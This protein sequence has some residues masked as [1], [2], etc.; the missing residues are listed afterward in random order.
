MTVV[1]ANMSEDMRR[2]DATSAMVSTQSTSPLAAIVD[3]MRIAIARYRYRR[4]IES[5]SRFRPHAAGLY[6]VTPIAFDTAFVTRGLEG[7]LRVW[8]LREEGQIALAAI[9]PMRC[10]RGLSAVIA[11]ERAPVV[12]CATSEG[13]ARWDLREPK[14]AHTD[15]FQGRLLHVSPDGEWLAAA[16]LRKVLL[17]HAP[18][19]RRTATPPMRQRKSRPYG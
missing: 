19:G 11:A 12:A 4:T 10:L 13:L 16:R 7:E 15:G 14:R 8:R 1:T 18:S 9:S 17:W 2:N 5:L 3:G 6:D